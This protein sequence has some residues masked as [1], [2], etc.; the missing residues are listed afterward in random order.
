MT[1]PV[2]KEDFNVPSDTTT[3]MSG[4]SCLFT[5]GMELFCTD[6]SLLVHMLVR[7]QKNFSLSGIQ[8]YRID[9]TVKRKMPG[10]CLKVSSAEGSS[11]LQVK[12]SHSQ[13]PAV[14]SRLWQLHQL[15]TSDY[16]RSLKNCKETDFFE[17]E[18]ENNQQNKNKMWIC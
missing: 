9:G 5:G 11:K 10:K 4:A 7:L 3:P 15:Q 6:G 8:F 14:L 13:L 17:E 16:F 2:D 1:F 12:Q 18:M